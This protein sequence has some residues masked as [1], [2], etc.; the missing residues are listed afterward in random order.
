VHR[1]GQ[2]VVVEFAVPFDHFQLPTGEVTVV[3]GA[4]ELGKAQVDPA[5]STPPGPHAAELLIR[6]ALRLGEDARW[7]EAGRFGIR[8]ETIARDGTRATFTLVV[9]TR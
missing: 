4:R 5:K 8:W 9:S 3:L 7:P 2:E 6:L 1:D